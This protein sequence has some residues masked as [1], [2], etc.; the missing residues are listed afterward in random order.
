MS[1]MP[2]RG[3]IDRR[4]FRAAGFADFRHNRREVWPGDATV[5]EHMKTIAATLLMA[6]LILGGRSA[7]AEQSP[8]LNDLN[9]ARAL[10]S[11]F[12]RD[13]EPINNYWRTWKAP[14]LVRIYA[15]LGDYSTA[16]EIAG[17][18]ADPKKQSNALSAIAYAALSRN[19]IEVV[20]RLVAD[21][22]LQNA[23]KRYLLEGLSYAFAN[24]RSY[25]AAFQQLKKRGGFSGLDA[26]NIR[27]IAVAAG[28]GLAFLALIE[29][30]EL[31]PKGK[32]NLIA[33]TLSDMASKGNWKL[34]TPYLDQVED[35]DYYDILAVAGI[36]QLKANDLSG[37]HDIAA[38]MITPAAGR[39]SFEY[40]S[41]A[42]VYIGLGGCP[43]TWPIR[44]PFERLMMIADCEYLPRPTVIGFIAA[45]YRHDRSLSWQLSDRLVERAHGIAKEALRSWRIDSAQSWESARGPSGVV[46][47]NAISLLEKIGRE[48][49]AADL[50]RA[51]TSAPVWRPWILADGIGLADPRLIEIKS[52]LLRGEDR[53]Q[54]LTSSL[55]HLLAA[56]K[57]EY[58]EIILKGNVDGIAAYGFLD[59]AY[60]LFRQ[61]DL[62]GAQITLDMLEANADRMAPFTPLYWLALADGRAAI[63]DEA[64]SLKVYQRV[65]DG[66]LKE[67]KS[68]SK[69]T[70]QGRALAHAVY[71][72][73]RAG[74]I[75][76]LMKLVGAIP[77]DPIKSECVFNLAIAFV[78]ADD[79]QTARNLAML[80]P[81]Q[82]FS[83]PHG[84]AETRLRVET[85]V[86]MRMAQT[87][88]L[89]DAVNAIRQK[90]KDYR[91]D[92][93]ATLASAVN[94]W[95]SWQIK[96]VVTP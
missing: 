69:S 36:V 24:K 42:G 78:N 57:F 47:L 37:A 2:Q 28:D 94:A 13:Y 20:E 15:S 61:K 25:A 52:N 4:L 43:G 82:S 79:F 19:Q 30:I 49:D 68:D 87:G 76:D 92:P 72:L 58:A 12:L 75:D 29:T 40:A 85:H 95:S 91:F 96:Q 16:L 66:L 41:F 27:R 88:H 39:A 33:S 74:R 86:I 44:A 38:M 11:N 55:Y 64:G 18:I 8:V 35:K 60:Q 14:E 9:A 70:G 45:L 73:H 62:E 83:D 17:N 89:T 67:I 81:E 48:S 1:R 65:L 32:S 59:A 53:N 71:F 93:V 77:N 80:L 54:F 56:K 84:S 6:W 31:S 22:R 90:S 23:S 50:I 3:K 10:V 46:L 7:L 21:E 51:A 26:W 34:V 5:D 63:G